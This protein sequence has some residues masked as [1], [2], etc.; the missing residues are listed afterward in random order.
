MKLRSPHLQ[1]DNAQ[2]HY[3]HFENTVPVYIVWYGKTYAWQ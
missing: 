3:L 2:S 1:F